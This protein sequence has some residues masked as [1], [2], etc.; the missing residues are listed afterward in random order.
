MASRFSAF[1][2]QSNRS[3][4]V[5]PASNSGALI[6]ALTD[7]KPKALKPVPWASN[8]PLDLGVEMTGRLQSLKLFNNWAIG[9]FY[10][11]G[12]LIKIKGEA[13]ADLK[14]G[15][16]YKLTGQ[17]VN[18]PKYG[19]SL[20]VFSAMPE[21]Y[22]EPNAIKKYLT[23]NFKG[24]GA[25]SAQKMVDFYLSM[26]EPDAL[27]K[28]RLQILNEPWTIDWTPAGR[29]GVSSSQSE[30]EIGYIRRDLAL[31]I[32]SI[33]GANRT[34]IMSLSKWLFE[35]R[36][37][38]PE[39]HAFRSPNAAAD[40]W[41]ILKHDPY[42]PSAEVSGYGFR[43]AD[44]VAS[45]LKIDAQDPR[46]LSA[47]VEYAL[48]EGCNT[49]GHVFLRLDDLKRSIIKVDPRVQSNVYDAIN[50]GLQE[51]IQID[52]VDGEDRYY[53]KKL[54]NSEKTVAKRLSGLMRSSEPLFTDDL[55]DEMIQSAFRTGKTNPQNWSLDDSQVQ[56]VRD[57]LTNPT[58]LH[59]LTGGPGCGK[60]ALVETVVRL[61]KNKQFEFCAPTGK[62]AK[63]LSSRISETGYSAST[64]HSLLQGSENNWRIH[65]GNPLDGHVLVVDEA[66]MP[67]LALWEGVLNAMNKT[68]HL[69]VVGDQNQLP[70]IQAGCVLHDMLQ[71]PGINHQQLTTVHRNSGGILDVVQEV[72]NGRINPVDRDSVKFSHGLYDAEDDFE[73]VVQTY[74]ASINRVGIE[75]ALLL[76]SRRQGSAD[77]PGWNT[78]YA[79]A[80]LRT[81]LNPTGVPISGTRL[82]EN[83]RI[84]IR[85]NM[86]IPQK[87]QGSGAH[88]APTTSATGETDSGESQD[89]RDE[90]VVNGDTGTIVG[91][92]L[93]RGEGKSGV[94]WL[95]LKLDDGRTIDFPGEEAN[96]LEHAYALTVHA[97]QGSEYKEIVG[98]FTSGMN[99]FINRNMLMTG[100]SRARERLF[101]FADDKVIARIA[102]TPQPPRNSSLIQRMATGAFVTEKPEDRQEF[103]QRCYGLESERFSLDDEDEDEDFIQKRIPCHEGHDSIRM[104]DIPAVS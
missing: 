14:E 20:D 30:D 84:I 82:F 53:T 22:L 36:A 7:R 78:T 31:K 85:K 34:V 28:F 83:D 8:K 87:E 39:G 93:N 5:P 59:V 71:L 76:I 68:M 32:G 61:L 13:L 24:I 26:P 46:R 15:L 65:R 66:S 63:V 17:M 41:Q 21:I 98:V 40:A 2:K 89:G 42:I 92:E 55:T 37:Q 9:E 104:A 86:T 1:N 94:Q 16:D 48:D 73:Q 91:Y 56:A 43:T 12:Q 72:C 96:Y 3:H 67:S 25:K 38:L 51:R 4:S 54:L 18:H 44:G 81:L 52:V 60:T 11:Q 27:E 101:V 19:Q 50:Y 45:S 77:E 6:G 57:M 103:I 79:N 100:L 75:N 23:Q 74:L 29:D 97:A 80:V 10:T 70:S 35:I 64:I 99:S 47:L 90:R 58:R 62:A 33:T 95:R 88:A 69:I 102:A 49:N